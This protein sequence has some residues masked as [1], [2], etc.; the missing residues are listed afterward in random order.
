[1]GAFQP[2]QH[3]L[4]AAAQNGAQILVLKKRSRDEIREGALARLVEASTL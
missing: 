3:A 1:M 4:G 2:A